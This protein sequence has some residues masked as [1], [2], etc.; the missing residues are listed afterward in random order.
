MLDP[1][2]PAPTVA[3]ALADAAAPPPPPPVAAAPVVTA[4]G[5]KTPWDLSRQDLAADDASEA[6]LGASG[7]TVALPA[8]LKPRGVEVVSQGFA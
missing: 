4:E 1:D 8:K 2:D 6:D 3:D 5:V 7:F